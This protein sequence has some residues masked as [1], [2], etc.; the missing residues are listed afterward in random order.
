M[1]YINKKRNYLETKLDFSKL[2]LEHL[3]REDYTK[4]IKLLNEYSETFYRE[5]ISLTFTNQHL[6]ILK[7]IVILLYINRESKIKIKVCW[8]KE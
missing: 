3:K 8:I 1:H 2:R 4:L 7:H 6:C 5:G